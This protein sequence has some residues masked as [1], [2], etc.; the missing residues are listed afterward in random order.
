MGK[1][2]AALGNIRSLGLWLS[3]PG[4]VQSRVGADE[5]S[6]RHAVMI[7]DKLHQKFD[8]IKKKEKMTRPVRGTLDT[9]ASKQ[10]YL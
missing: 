4:V 6:G 8:I 9:K 3:L 7:V 1:P 2:G 10:G 5:V